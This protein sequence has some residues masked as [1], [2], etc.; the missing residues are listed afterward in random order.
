MHEAYVVKNKHSSIFRYF[1]VSSIH[2][3]HLFLYFKIQVK[4]EGVKD[5]MKTAAQDIVRI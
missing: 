3:C 4:H 5:I 1:F 2:D